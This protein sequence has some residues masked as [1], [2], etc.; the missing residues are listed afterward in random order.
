MSLSQPNRSP[1]PSVE[2]K[3]W[4]RLAVI[5]LFAVF[6]GF[7]LGSVAPAILVWLHSIIS[8][9]VSRGQAPAPGTPVEQAKFDSLAHIVPFALLGM[10]LGG[11][12]GVRFLRALE[13]VGMRWDKM[14]TGDKVTFFVGTFLGLIASVPLLLMFQ[15]LEMPAF[16]R[17][18][19][20]AGVELGFGSL[21][22]YA[23]QSMADILPW[24]RNRGPKKRSGIKIIDTNVIIDGR[25]HDVMK[26]GFLDGNL[27]V[28]GFVLEELQYIADSHDS[29]RRQRGRRGLDV[30]RH[31]Q[32]DFEMD[33]QIHDKLAADLNDG[34]DAR[35]VR[36][37]KE[38]GADIITNDHNLRRVA[39]LQEVRVMS[40]N[41]LALALRTNILPQETMELMIIREGNQ[42]GQG[43]GYLDDGTMIVVENGKNH[44]GETVEIV[45][46]QVHQTE[47]GKMIFGEIE[48]EE[49][50]RERRRPPRPR[51]NA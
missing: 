42:Y 31:M 20:I 35:L 15:A 22:V 47:R 14:H 9:L 44:I 41:D 33:I 6:G 1:W 39:E 3:N 21:S 25:I 40:L 34:V 19:L 46:T 36:L 24:N 50:V 38:L 7:L 30:L 2:P 13:R 17:G 48:G 12:T 8:N 10:I 23:L 28:P 43:I 4:A 18:L 27:Y 11:Y 26:T 49:V 5:L 32:H 37:A 51:T 45:V 29:L 16:Y